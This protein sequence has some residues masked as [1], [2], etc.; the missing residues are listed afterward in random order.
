MYAKANPP[1][2]HV[3]ARYLFTREYPP[4][5]SC[6]PYPAPT[7]QR[8]LTS[9]PHPTSGQQP[10]LDAIHRVI[11]SSHHDSRNGIPLRR[12]LWPAG[13]CRFAGRLDHLRGQPR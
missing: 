5:R 2:E 7:K 8:L 10:I 9:Y 1:T 4:C 6:L 3:L 12:P 13:L 11:I